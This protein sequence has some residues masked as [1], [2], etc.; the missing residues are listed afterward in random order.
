[1]AIYIWNLNDVEAKCKEREIARLCKGASMLLHNR[2]K[3]LLAALDSNIIDFFLHI[4]S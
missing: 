4:G 1:V 3:A 2:P